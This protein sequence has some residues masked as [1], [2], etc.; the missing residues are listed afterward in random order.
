MQ[1]LLEQ[2]NVQ[3]RSM[4]SYIQRLLLVLAR[5][6]LHDTSHLYR[7]RSQNNNGSCSHTKRRNSPSSRRSS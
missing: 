1:A 5:P 2:Q 3:T 7:R 6:S 4:R